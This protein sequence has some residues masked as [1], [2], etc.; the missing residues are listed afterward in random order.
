MITKCLD[1][2]SILYMEKNIKAFHFVKY[3]FIFFEFLNELLK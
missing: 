1:Y 3:Y 2:F